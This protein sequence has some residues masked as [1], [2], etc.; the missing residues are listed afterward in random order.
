MAELFKCDDS[1]LGE[2]KFKSVGYTE[3]DVR[4]LVVWAAGLV[5]WHHGTE[6]DGKLTPMPIA[7]FR[8]LLDGGDRAKA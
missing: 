6:V 1:E 2:D 4:A 7:P 8:A 5:E 3:D